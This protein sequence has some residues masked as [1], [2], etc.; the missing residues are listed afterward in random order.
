MIRTAIKFMLYEKSKSLGILVAIIISIFLIGQQLS[1]LNFL[2]SL[3]SVTVTQSD[4][5]NADI[6]VITD[7][8]DNA[9]RLKPIGAS[10]VQL[11]KSIEGV[12]ASYPVLISN[13][14]L[15]FSDGQFSNVR[16]VGSEAPSLTIGP[17]PAYIYKGDRNAIAAPMAFTCDISSGDSFHHPVESGMEIEL[18]GRRARIATLTKDLKGFGDALMYS[19]LENVRAVAGIPRDEISAVVIKVKDDFD[20]GKVA[21]GINRSFT[22]IKAWTRQDIKEATVDSILNETSMGLSFLSLVVFAT[23]SGFFIIGLTLYT[24]TFD[25]VRDYGTLKAIGA[26]N[27]YISTLVLVQAALYGITG[28]MLAVFLLYTMKWGVA[29]SGLNLTVTPG[30]LGLLFALTLFISIGGSMMAVRKLAKIEPASVFK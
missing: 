21:A 4:P 7:Q 20:P 5:E 29:G 1:T 23:V 27:R 17:D 13:A 28:Y 26:T 15:K 12:E 11:V 9:N 14:I 25:R 2:Q 18:N 8:S 10:F 16:L 24:A 3:M 22:G 30:L 6:W 19:T